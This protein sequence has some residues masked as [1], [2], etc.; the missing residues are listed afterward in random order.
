MFDQRVSWKFSLEEVKAHTKLSI[1]FNSVTNEII[2]DGI[3]DTEY[4]HPYIERVFPLL[5]LYKSKNKGGILHD[6]MESSMLLRYND[7]IV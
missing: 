1:N 4:V 6:K 5:K 2:D 7:I 3:N